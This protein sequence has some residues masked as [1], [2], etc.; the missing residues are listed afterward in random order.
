MRY[1][2]T[3]ESK[4]NWKKTDFWILPTK[5]P[6]YLLALEKIGLPK[7]LIDLW[8][9]LKYKNDEGYIIFLGK[10]NNWYLR[11]YYWLEYLKN[12]KGYK[13]RGKIEVSQDEIDEYLAREAA[14]KYNL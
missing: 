13:Y 10:G 8:S 5:H 6:E 14:K 12:S 9:G 3:Y 7:N 1:I 11:E 4:T 2:K